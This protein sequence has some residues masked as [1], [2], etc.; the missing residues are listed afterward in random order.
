MERLERA[1]Y[2][3]ETRLRKRRGHRA[4][5]EAIRIEVDETYSDEFLK[6]LIELNP[7]TFARC[8]L[9]KG[10][11]PGITLVEIEPRSAKPVSPVDLQAT[12]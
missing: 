12:K 9:K 3:V 1:K 10:N 4:S 8:I 6:R 2:H 11:K 7:L 5:F